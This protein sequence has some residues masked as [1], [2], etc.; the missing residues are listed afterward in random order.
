MSNFEEFRRLVLREKD[1]QT[2]LRDV[3]DRERFTAAVVDLGRDRGFLF[4]PDDVE[5]ALNAGRRA[6]IERWI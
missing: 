4:S 3:D 2:E 6:W 5:A 1:L